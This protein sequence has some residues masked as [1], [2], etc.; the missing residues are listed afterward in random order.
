MNIITLSGRLVAAPELRTTTNGVSV[1][2][3]K[4]AV[5][6]GYGDKKTTDFIPLVFWRG[7]AETAAKYANKGY[8]LIVSGSLQTRQYDDKN[9]NKRTAYEVVV[10]EMELPPKKEIAEEVNDIY[11]TDEDLPF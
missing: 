3:A 7:L 9:G 5:D 10:S 4:L 2:T 6:R 8:K 1:A 11:E